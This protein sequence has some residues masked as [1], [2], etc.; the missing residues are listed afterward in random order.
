MRTLMD[1]VDVRPGLA[2]TTVVLRHRLHDATRR[3]ALT[4]VG[5]RA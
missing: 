3:P 5:G 1:E 4:S 2:G